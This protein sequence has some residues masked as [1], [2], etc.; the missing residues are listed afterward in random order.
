MAIME[1]YSA[2]KMLRR[3]FTRSGCAEFSHGL[4]GL[5]GVL[6]GVR[7]I[8]HLRST[9]TCCHPEHNSNRVLQRS[10][11]SALS[12]VL[13]HVRIECV[14]ERSGLEQRLSPI[15]IGTEAW[16]RASGR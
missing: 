9:Q 11:H 2:S 5:C 6:A 8:R 16:V 14:V 7:P 12:P 13:S 10:S 3:V 15:A 1:E 4:E